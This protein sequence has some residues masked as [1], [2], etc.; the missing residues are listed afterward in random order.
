M[1]SGFRSI[2]AKKK[3]KVLEVDMRDTGLSKRRWAV[4][5]SKRQSSHVPL[6]LEGTATLDFSVVPLTSRPDAYGEL[7]AAI[8]LSLIFFF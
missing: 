8:F 4:S 5:T 3:K 6:L 1:D 2:L 7:V